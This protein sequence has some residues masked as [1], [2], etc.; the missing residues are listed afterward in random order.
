MKVLIL[1]LSLFA[2]SVAQNVS[3]TSDAATAS[4]KCYM[5]YFKMFGF[6]QVPAY[7]DF[8]GAVR[9]LE[10][11]QGIQATKD[12]C[13][14]FNALNS[15]LTPVI[16]GCNNTQGYQQILGSDNTNAQEYF[17]FYSAERFECNEGFNSLMNNYYC[18]ISVQQNHAAE[19]QE[20]ATNF[21]NSVNDNPFNCS[22]IS[23]YVTCMTNEYQQYCGTSGAGFVCTVSTIEMDAVIPSCTGT[24]PKCPNYNK[25]NS[26]HNLNSYTKFVPRVKFLK[27]HV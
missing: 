5:T 16:G 24:T 19:V 14:W 2:L 11:G 25:L 22:F 26:F 10:A 20:C 23:D 1:L 4:N 8:L 9:T 18:F 13:G 17:M 6:S 12:M 15:C 3:C 27:H 7:Q 21:T